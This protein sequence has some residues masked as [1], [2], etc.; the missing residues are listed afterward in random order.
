MVAQARRPEPQFGDWFSSALRLL[1]IVPAIG[2]FAGLVTFLGRLYLESYYSFFGIPPSALAFE[3]QDYAFGSFPLILFV[4]VVTVT[5]V[6]YWWID[7]PGLLAM[8]AERLATRI[9]KLNSEALEA[10]RFWLLPE[11]DRMRRQSWEQ[12]KEVKL[13][14]VKP[15]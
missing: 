8:F 3:V 4:L 14:E 2:A 12:P 1:P 7:R 13:E 11:S 5:V 15:D 10:L 9:N 6:T